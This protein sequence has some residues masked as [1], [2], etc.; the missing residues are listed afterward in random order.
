[1]AVSTTSYFSNAT[2]GVPQVAGDFNVFQIDTTPKLAIGTKFERQDGAVFRYSHFGVAITSAGLV[3][4]SSITNNMVNTAACVVA[5]SSTYQM[6]VEQSGTYPN[7]KGSKFMIITKASITADDFQGCYAVIGST[8]LLHNT[9]YTYRVKGNTAT[10][11]PVSG[12]LRLEL[13]DKLQ[14]N[15]N[16]STNVTIAGNAYSSLEPAFMYTNAVLAG[17]SMTS[18]SA[19][20]RWGWIQ[21]KGIVAVL[22]DVNAQSLLAFGTMAALSSGTAGAVTGASIYTSGTCTQW[23]RPTVGYTVAPGASGCW[24]PIKVNL[25]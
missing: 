6:P 15:L 20:D 19:A 5:S 4:A 16:S 22:Q 13:Y 7:M 3:L 1:M 11:D 12:S 10:G 8:G 14:A 23:L 21:T 18:S 24:T 25:E 9:G 2:V 17:V